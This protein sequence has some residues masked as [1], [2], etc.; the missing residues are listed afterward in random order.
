MR[1]IPVCPDM[2]KGD[3]QLNWPVGG[4]CV[5]LACGGFLLH[6]SQ[7]HCDVSFLISDAAD[8]RATRHDR[9]VR[10]GDPGMVPA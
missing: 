9:R 10:G 8:P 6:I 7:R 2:G 1:E 3:E 5:A 4:W